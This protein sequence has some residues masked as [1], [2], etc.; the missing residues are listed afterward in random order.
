MSKNV[1]QLDES[2]EPEGGLFYLVDQELTD[3][4]ISFETLTNKFRDLIFGKEISIF[5]EGIPD[6]AEVVLVYIA[7][8]AF[9]L[10]KLNGFAGTAASVDSTIT[11]AKNGDEFA[12]LLFTAGSTTPT[13][14]ITETAFVEG[15]VVTITFPL[16][17][18]ESLSDVSISISG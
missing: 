11:I 17:A 8:R 12:S 10:S 2:T 13:P 3:K 1:T 18:D 14:T 5:V 7:P 16:V 6:S 9:K 4:K 15:D